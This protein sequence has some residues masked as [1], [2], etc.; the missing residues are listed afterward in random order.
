MRFHHAIAAAWLFLIC[1]VAP[2][3]AE[4]R[5]ALVVGNGAYRHADRL[6]NPVNDARAMRDALK[7]PAL[8]FDVVYGED[9]DH[10]GM[11]RRIG[12][13]AGLAGG[14]D[15]AIV[16]FAGHGA[17]F[18]D[19]PYVVPVDAEFSKLDQM[20]YELIAVETLI[21]EL[22]RATGVRIAILDACRDNGAERRLKQARG[23]AT[24]G[25]GPVK[26]PDGLIM[27][28]ATQHL[29]T[30]ADSGGGGHS[31]FTAAL[32][33]NIATPG[34]DVKDVFF[35]IGRDVVK[36]TD[37]RQRPEISVSIFE[38]YAL[39]P[40]AAA[41]G[42]ALPT[43]PP[44]FAVPPPTPRPLSVN[45]PLT[46]ER[47]RGLTPKDTFRECADCPEMVVVPAGSFT[48]GSPQNEKDRR[49]DE[50]PQHTVMIGRAFAAGRF[51][52]T[53]GQFAAFVQKT[54]YLT[55]G[56]CLFAEDKDMR[57]YWRGLGLAQDGS[58]PAVC[59]GFDDAK[60]YVDWVAKETGKP[61]RLLSESEWEYAARGQTSPGAYPR[62]W[63][64][65][66]EKVLC[67][68]GNFLDRQGGWKDAPCDD[69]YKDTSPVGH[70]EPN[71]F[72]LHDMAGNAAQF[73]ADCW[74][75]NYNGAPADGSARNDGCERSRVVRGGAFNTYPDGLR[76]AARS[77]LWAASTGIGFRVAR[78]L[79]P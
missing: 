13:F 37:G 52:V 8:G 67:R 76:A 71:A 16:Y 42:N 35:N 24:R 12:E 32:L 38:R 9:L 48:M 18:G 44:G 59:V 61:Y 14:A 65:N 74:H 43:A 64:G 57:A 25:L 47:E 28:Y 66:D 77:G 11:R 31:P 54:G 20:A 60:A 36:A 63:F 2:A 17:T 45:A 19:T 78:T 69:G 72:G 41:G 4:K 62:F 27:A 3:L 6:D 56:T 39:V 10:A 73:T 5:V 34:L 50:G 33:Q 46:A 40:A 55:S 75:D 15:V 51:H 23:E 1:A 68:Y 58:H 79:G 70:Y 49:S 26:N 29:S 21:G 7:V 22:R 30:A 53:H